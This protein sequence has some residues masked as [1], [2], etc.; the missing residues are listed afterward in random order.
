MQEAAWERAATTDEVATMCSLLD[1]ALRFGALG[2]SINHF[3]KDRSL[4]LVPGY[5]ADDEEFAALFAVVAQYLGRTVQVITRFNDPDHYLSDGERFARLCQR[6]GVRAQWPGVPTDVLDRDKRDPLWDLHRRL[7]ADGVDFWSTVAYKPLEP[8]FGFEKSIVFQRVPAWNELVNGPAEEKL[9]RLADPAWRARA[10]HEWDDRPHVATSRVDR[11]HSLVFAL[12]ETGAG[13][14]GISLA[15]YAGQTG[16][17]VSDAL[18]EWLVRNGIGSSLVGTPDA[19][20]EDDVVELLR[21]PHTISNV[22]DS[23]AHLQLFCGAGQDIYIL[24]HYVRDTGRLRIEE[25]VHALTGRTASFFGLSDRGHIAPGKIG[26]LAVFALDEIELR[27]EVRCYD[28]PDGTW[29][30]SRPPAGFRATTVRGTPTWLDGQSTGA[31]PGTVDSPF[32][33]R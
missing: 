31:H 21:D 29:R 18:A 9:A 6:V 12:S 5:F 15:E 4:R 23:G 32:W 3:D 8:F 24:T 30:F 26:D 11:P 17:H 14:L 13:P 33:Q 19:L 27:Q 7:A 2:L 16:L 20:A 10:R 22:N 25:A 28:V 1:E